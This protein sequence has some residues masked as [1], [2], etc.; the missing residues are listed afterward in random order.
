MN[1]Q[2]TRTL[3]SG[4][5]SAFASSLRTPQMYCV[6]MWTSIASPRHWQTHWCVSI[7]L[8]LSVCVQ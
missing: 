4:R 7:E 2:M 5:P 6:E 3:S 8:W 1:S